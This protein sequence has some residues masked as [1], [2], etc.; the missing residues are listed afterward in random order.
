MKVVQKYP[1]L[2]NNK[3]PDFHEKSVKEKAWQLYGMEMG[4]SRI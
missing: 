2:Y 3:L 1:A 4:V